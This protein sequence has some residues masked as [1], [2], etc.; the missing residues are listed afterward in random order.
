[1]SSLTVA[2]CYTEL[3]GANPSAEDEAPVGEDGAPAVM[4]LDIQDAFRLVEVES[5]VKPSKDAFKSHL[6][7]M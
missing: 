4:V 1:M 5:D 3:E 7:S 6:K 2:L